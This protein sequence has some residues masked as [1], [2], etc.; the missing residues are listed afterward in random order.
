M[1]GNPDKKDPER[2]HDAAQELLSGAWGPLLESSDT[3]VDQ[4]KTSSLAL[5]AALMDLEVEAELWWMNEHRLRD[6][7]A[8][9][10]VVAVHHPDAMVGSDMSG[11]QWGEHPGYQ[12]RLCYM[13]N[14]YVRKKRVNLDDP[15]DR[16]THR[17]PAAWKH[18]VEKTNPPKVKDILDKAFDDETA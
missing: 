10:F 17:I 9:H 5:M 6:D 8:E 18:L 15:K 1:A 13:L 7:V 3:A 16:A 2:A 12:S 4:C 11:A 14:P